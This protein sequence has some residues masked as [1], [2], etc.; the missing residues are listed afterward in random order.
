MCSEEDQAC[1]TAASHTL[2]LGLLS[3]DRVGAGGN[4]VLIVRILGS[5][6]PLMVQLLEGIPACLSTRLGVQRHDGVIGDPRHGCLA[7]KGNWKLFG[8]VLGERGH[9]LR[10]VAAPGPPATCNTALT[11]HQ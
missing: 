4:T 8:D 1:V 10:S 5:V 6:E 2:D 11:I 9:E 3:L 7:H